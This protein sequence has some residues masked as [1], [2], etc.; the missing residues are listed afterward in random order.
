MPKYLADTILQ[1]IRLPPR[2]V[3]VSRLSSLNAAAL[4]EA[5]IEI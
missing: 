3:I 2:G 1:W 4:G 5:L